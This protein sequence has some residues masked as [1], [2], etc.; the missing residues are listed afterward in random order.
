MIKF[1]HLFLKGLEFGNIEGY[2]N[3]TDLVTRVL[4]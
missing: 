3:I 1:L 2:D 4:D